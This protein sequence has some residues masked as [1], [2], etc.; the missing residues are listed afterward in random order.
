MVYKTFFTS[1]LTI[2]FFA[3]LQ[4]REEMIL[5]E[6]EPVIPEDSTKI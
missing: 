2:C 6:K 1:L 5:H 4:A 3:S